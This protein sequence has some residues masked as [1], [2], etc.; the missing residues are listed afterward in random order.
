[1]YLHHTEVQAT[2]DVIYTCSGYVLKTTRLCL[3]NSTKGLPNEMITEL[4]FT[5]S[6]M[7]F[8]SKVH[9]RCQSVWQN[10]QFLFSE[11]QKT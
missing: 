9:C 3:L 6:F 8:L 10:G 4:D 5:S 7:S 11:Y 1:M 2:Q